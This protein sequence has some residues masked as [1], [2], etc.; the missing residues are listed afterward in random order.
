[1]PLF[2]VMKKTSAVRIYRIDTDQKTDKKIVA[3]FKQQ[4]IDFEKNH[5]KALPFEAGYSPDSNECSIINN[6][7]EAAPLLDAVKR[8]T[9]MPKWDGTIGLEDVT[10]LFMAPE[11]P[12]NKDKIAIQIFSKKQI[13]KSSKYLWLNNNVFS[14]SDLL[15]FNIDDKLVAIIENQSI[16]F[17]SFTSLRSILI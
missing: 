11:Y 13:L 3:T 8:S 14:M 5:P 10:A 1:M 6:F 15:G 7:V 17:R 9:A 2:A 12:A 16:K 4:L